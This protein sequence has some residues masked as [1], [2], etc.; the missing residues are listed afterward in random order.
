MPWLD[1]YQAEILASI[2][3]TLVVGMMFI[4]GNVGWAWAKMTARRLRAKRAP[5]EGKRGLGG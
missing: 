2:L 1:P 5:A 4:C 3:G